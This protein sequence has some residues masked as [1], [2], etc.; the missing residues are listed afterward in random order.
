MKRRFEGE[1]D[2][3]VGKPFRGLALG[4]GVAQCLDTA[5]REIRALLWG[6]VTSLMRA[7]YH[8][9]TRECETTDDD[10]L[11]DAN[12]RHLCNIHAHLLLTLRN[13]PT[14]Q[15]TSERATAVVVGM[16]FL[17][18]RHEWNMNLLDKKGAAS[19][20]GW[21]VPENEVHSTL[22]LIPTAKPL[23]PKPDPNG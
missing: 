9:L 21:R 15:L 10:A 20:D 18:T 19:Y 3:L 4:P 12:T 16:V 22:T 23:S 1:H 14:S 6:E 13:C 11:L 5:Q 7:W 8:K 2:A 17:S